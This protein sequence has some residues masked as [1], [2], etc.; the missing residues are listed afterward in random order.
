[1]LD[2]RVFSDQCHASP[3]DAKC[4]VLYDVSSKSQ[5]SNSPGF[6]SAI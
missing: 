2:Y 6:V 5:C 1:M 4:E 3:M